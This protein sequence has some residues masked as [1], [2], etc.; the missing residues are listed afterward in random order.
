VREWLDREVSYQAGANRSRVLKQLRNAESFS[1][2]FAELSALSL[3]REELDCDVVLEAELDG[4]TPDL[5]VRSR[6]NGGDQFIAE[7]WTRTIPADIVKRE[8]NW[9]LLSKAVGRI[10]IPVQLDLHVAGTAELRPPGDAERKRIVQDLRRW[11]GSGARHPRARVTSCGLTFEVV[12][13]TRARASLLPI[14]VV[15][16][17]D[18]DRIVDAI[19]AKVVKYRKVAA[20]RGLPLVVI[21]SAQARTGLTRD[22]VEEV[23]RGKNVL[24]F[25]FDL[26]TLGRMTSAPRTLRKSAAPPAFDATLSAVAFLDV[27]AG[28]DAHISVWPINGASR[29]LTSLTNS[30]RVEVRELPRSR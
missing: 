15:R 29:P 20:S 22:V 26:R 30:R 1:A 6:E 17:I 24:V 11:L 12:G 27:R 23:L 14:S 9:L 13:A 3:L 7:V 25:D 4:Q 19:E 28:Y 5:V 10:P 2:A 8:Q 21:V 16:T 18:R